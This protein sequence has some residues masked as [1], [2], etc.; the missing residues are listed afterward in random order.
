MCHVPAE[1]VN[2]LWSPS[3]AELL[4]QGLGLIWI[5]ECS[6]RYLCLANEE[7]KGGVFILDAVESRFRSEIEKKLNIFLLILWEV[8]SYMCR[9][10]FDHSHPS[11]L[12]SNASQIHPLPSPSQ[13]YVSFLFFNNLSSPVCAAHILMSKASTGAWSPY[14][15]PH[16]KENRLSLLS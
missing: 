5:T 11:S 3:C 10:Y 13:L 9:M 15:G 4:Y 14:Q 8:H 1:R 16:H 6:D 12:P 7:M 2:M